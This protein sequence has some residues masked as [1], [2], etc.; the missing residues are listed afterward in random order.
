[1]V[2]RVEITN[3]ACLFERQPWPTLATIGWG[4]GK[5]EGAFKDVGTREMRPSR[6]RPV[7]V[8]FHTHTHTLTLASPLIPCLIRPDPLLLLKQLCKDA[9]PRCVL[10]EKTKWNIT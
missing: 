10:F 6:T 8:F 1:M 2:A 5:G 7:Q 4:R 9:L 3:V